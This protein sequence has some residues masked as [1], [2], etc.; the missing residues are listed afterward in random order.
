MV[1]I[2]VQN[3]QHTGDTQMLAFIRRL[4]QSSHQRFSNRELE[5]YA[6]TEYRNDWQWVIN[7]YERTG[8]LPQVGVRIQ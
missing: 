8:T 2:V 4:F 7:Y 5:V 1:N 6:K 3:T